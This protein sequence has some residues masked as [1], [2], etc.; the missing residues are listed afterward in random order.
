VVNCM[1]GRILISYISTLV[2]VVVAVRIKF[3]MLL[4]PLPILFFL[5]SLRWC[6]GIVIWVSMGFCGFSLI[7]RV[8]LTKLYFFFVFIFFS[9]TYIRTGTC[10]HTTP[11]PIRD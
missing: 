2:L 5:P 1:I 3:T 11:R 6:V 10:F 8:N 7:R 4:L 9:Y